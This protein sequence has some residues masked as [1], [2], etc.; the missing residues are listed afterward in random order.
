MNPRD[1][2]NNPNV[3]QYLDFIASAEDT[4]KYGYNT[5]FG[6][7]KFDDLN[8]HPNQ[9]IEFTRTDGK[10]DLSS[11]AGRYQFI[12][13]TWN[14]LAK[15]YGLQDFSPE[16]QDIGAI[17]LINRGGALEDVLSG[18]FDAATQKLG[19]TWASLPSSPYKQPN[20]SQEWV[21]NYFGNTPQQ[22][23][24]NGNLDSVLSQLASYYERPSQTPTANNQQPEWS[25]WQQQILERSIDE[26]ADNVREQ[27]LA[28]LLGER[29]RQYG[30]LPESLERA[31]NLVVSNL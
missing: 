22:T 18:N 9:K 12:A 3:R 11:A 16:S 28:K 7:T 14:E 6:G 30:T 10:K 17:A 1:Y 21:D 5:L 15:T 29:P 4:N 26:D 23:A 25:G 19:K 8:Q 13:P 2:L 24:Q 27:T 20:R 31:I